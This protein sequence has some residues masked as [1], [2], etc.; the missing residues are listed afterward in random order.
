[1][2]AL[3]IICI[4]LSCGIVVL[5]QS[6]TRVTN[7]FIYIDKGEY[8]INPDY[9][10]VIRRVNMNSTRRLLSR[11][12]N[13]ETKYRQH[14]NIHDP[15]NFVRRSQ[16]WILMDK[17]FKSSNQAGDYCW[18]QFF[19]TSPEVRNNYDLDRL[20][21]LLSHDHYRAYANVRYNNKSKSF[22]YIS[23]NQPIK[24]NSIVDISKMTPTNDTITPIVLIT[25]Y[26]YTEKYKPQLLMK[27]TMQRGR[28]S[29][30]CV[31]PSD[32]IKSS[33]MRLC[34]SNNIQAK[35]AISTCRKIIN[36]ILQDLQQP[37]GKK[38]GPRALLNFNICLFSCDQGEPNHDIPDIDIDSINE[39][40]KT[41]TKLLNLV[42]NSVDSIKRL[43]SD[44]YSKLD[45]LNYHN[46]VMSAIEYITFHARS[47]YATIVQL[48]QMNQVGNP[49]YEIIKPEEITALSDT[50][51]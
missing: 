47:Q 27:N 32:K 19:G 35:E 6:L 44:V 15:E 30:I 43:I 25:Y 28:D 48:H 26:Y 34:K 3:G 20:K 21:D 16:N 51:N 39:N 37:V 12:N 29:T 5:S 49:T 22:T 41:I 33:L 40:F 14:C 36:K 8:L 1:M 31:I 13:I 17:Q 24:D 50:L 23:D 42:K 9:L 38:R 4:A 18:D 11:L 10:R 46:K 2:Q 45:M 7:D